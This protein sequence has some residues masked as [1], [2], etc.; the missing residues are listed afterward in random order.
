[1]PKK[2][3]KQTKKR[4][5]DSPTDQSGLIAK[6]KNSQ[7]S[8]RTKSVLDNRSHRTTLRIS[9]RRP[10]TSCTKRSVIWGIAMRS[11]QLLP[12]RLAASFAC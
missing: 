3:A 4:R 11:Y 9:C 12:P 1:M 6:G 8:A 2:T 5:A 10:L 7:R